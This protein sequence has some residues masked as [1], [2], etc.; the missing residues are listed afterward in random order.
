MMNIIK[1]I[2]SKLLDYK[3]YISRATSYIA[4]VNTGMILMLFLSK[5]EDYGID[6]ELQNWGLPIYIITLILCVFIGY[7]DVK[8]GLY[9]SEIGKSQQQNPQ[10]LHMMQEL[11]DIKEELRKQNEINERRNNKRIR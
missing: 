10:I 4:I 11:K 8:L 6:I 1:K 5:L 7:L 2:V 9:K 3:I